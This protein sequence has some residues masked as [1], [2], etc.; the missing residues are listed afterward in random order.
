MMT[1]QNIL[2]CR[3]NLILNMLIMMQ[4]KLF[5]VTK[6]GKN[7]L[8]KN[9]KSLV[10]IKNRLA[11]ISH[12]WNIHLYNYNGILIRI[13]TCNLS[14]YLK[15]GTF[16]CPSANNVLFSETKTNYIDET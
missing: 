9:T 6:L 16:C 7:I 15:Y 2:T 8:K 10:L 13:I 4:Y 12:Y 3:K 11:K 5:K 1:L 14:F